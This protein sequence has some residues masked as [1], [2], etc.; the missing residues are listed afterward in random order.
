MI[1]PAHPFARATWDLLMV[2]HDQQL[3]PPMSLTWD[4]Y[5]QVLGVQV[6]AEN[7][8]LWLGAVAEATTETQTYEE[9]VHR[10]AIGQLRAAP[11]TRVRLITV[12]DAVAAS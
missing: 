6:P 3:P 5:G 9:S 12:T 7:Y 1:D 11:A 10:T 4:Q 2:M 8:L